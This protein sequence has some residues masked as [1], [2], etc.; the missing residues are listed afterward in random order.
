MKCSN[1]QALESFVLATYPGVET[2]KPTQEQ[3][4]FTFKC[5]LVM[6]IYTTGTVNFQGNSGNSTTMIGIVN[7]INSINGAQ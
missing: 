1:I 7:V 6:N 3:H 4:K 5:G 2:D